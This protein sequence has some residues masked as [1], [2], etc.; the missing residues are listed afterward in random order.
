[1]FLYNTSVFFGPL[2]TSHIPDV[3]FSFWCQNTSE[4]LTAVVS[5][6]VPVTVATADRMRQTAAQADGCPHN[7]LFYEAISSNCMANWEVFRINYKP[8]PP[9]MMEIL[10]QLYTLLNSPIMTP[11]SP[12]EQS[13]GK[14]D[15]QR[16]AIYRIPKCFIHVHTHSAALF[17]YLFN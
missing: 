1:M 4:I 6:A 9:Q 12:R 15:M 7:S 11:L 2:I 13:T 16:F 8:F 10:F 3:I 14:I 5:Q 17:I